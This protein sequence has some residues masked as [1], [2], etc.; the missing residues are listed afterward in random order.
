MG[1]CI[2]KP[3][4]YK[5]NDQNVQPLFSYLLRTGED[6]PSRLSGERLCSVNNCNYC[7]ELNKK[8][9]ITVSNNESPEETKQYGRYTINTI[10]SH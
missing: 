3:K 4:S 8:F 5:T 10:V 7:K 1:L 6:F 2:T 9:I